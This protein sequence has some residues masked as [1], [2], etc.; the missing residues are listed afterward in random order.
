MTV[1][2]ISRRGAVAL[3]CGVSVPWHVAAQ[4]PSV[5]VVG[6][7]STAYASRQTGDGFVAVRQGLAEEGFVVG[8]NV[9]LDLRGA[10]GHI[11]QLP[12]IAADL[13]SRGVAVL[14]TFG[15]NEAA[16]AAKSTTATIPIVFHVGDD[17]VEMG[18]VPTLTHPRGNAT[19][20]SLF[21]FELAERRLDILHQLV[22]RAAI[23]ASLIAARPSSSK[24]PIGTA[25]NDFGLKVI[26]FQANSDDDFEPV[27]ASAAR[28]GAGGVLVG[29][30]P[31]FRRRRAEIVALAS[32]YRLPTIYPWQEFADVGGLLSYGPDLYESYKQLGRYAGLILKGASPGELPVQL[33]TKFRLVINLAT[34]KTLGLSFP[35]SLTALADKV[36]Y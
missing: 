24:E 28:S 8:A 19:G 33:P 23:L 31:F 2:K 3:V 34:A 4:S 6:L 26:I 14:V 22:P 18:L 21:S 9:V 32:H 15:G 13:V 12:A 17:P 27:F 10:E 20:V 25:A 35:R 1:P 11:E 36:I 30:A 29:A 16:F 5:R 7:L